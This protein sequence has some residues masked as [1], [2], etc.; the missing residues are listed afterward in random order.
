MRIF[1]GYIYRDATI[2]EVAS[3]ERTY[4]IFAELERVR[5]MTET[6]VTR[7]LIAHQ[8]NTLAVDDN[9]ASRMTEFFPELTGDGA[10]ITAGTRI[11]WR[12]QLKRAAVDLWDNPDSTPDAAPNLWEDIDYKDGVRIIPEIITAGTAFAL[13][14]LGWWGDTLYRSKLAAN[15]YTPEQYPAGWEKALQ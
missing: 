11:N 4:R 6:E 13:D 12:G 14:E 5:P 3:V 9:T 15:T 2:E 1:D 8:I 7:L 10:L